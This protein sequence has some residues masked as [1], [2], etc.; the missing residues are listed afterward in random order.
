M[1]NWEALLA[2]TETVDDIDSSKFQDLKTYINAQIEIDLG[3]INQADFEARFPEG[4]L[5]TLTT[6]DIAHRLYLISNMDRQEP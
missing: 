6:T 4:E 1:D 2:G 5:S 3:D